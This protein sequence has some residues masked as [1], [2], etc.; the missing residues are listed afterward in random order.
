M[1]IVGFVVGIGGATCANAEYPLASPASAN[2]D[3]PKNLNEFI[4]YIER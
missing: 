1:G 3:A 4:Y 2:M